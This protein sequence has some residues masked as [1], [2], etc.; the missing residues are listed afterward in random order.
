MV[1]SSCKKEGPECEFVETS[2]TATGA[3]I[4]HLQ[5]F[6]SANSIVALQHSSG[7][8]Y[9]VHEPGESLHP[10]ICST[11]FIKYT[12]R[13][14]ETGQP[15]D[16]NLNGYSIVL[17]G[18]IAGAQ[19]GLKLIGKTGKIDLYIPPSLAYNDRVIRNQSGQVVIPAYSY[20]KFEF[21]LV[22]FQ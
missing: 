22:D 12:G 6:L 4:T 10:E 19:K 2:K 8:F 5:N 18:L 14:M 13:L 11:V 3:E 17:G 15:F 1:I 16:Q 7:L 20:L 9:V 21:E